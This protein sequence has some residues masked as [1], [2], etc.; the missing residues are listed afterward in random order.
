MVR[1]NQSIFSLK[2]WLFT[3]A[4]KAGSFA[5]AAEVHADALIID[6]ESR[7]ITFH[8]LY[9]STPPAPELVSTTFR[10]SST[11]QPNLITSFSPSATLRQSSI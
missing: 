10:R 9:E 5:R 2:S 8:V 6:L 4:T 1:S 3:P 11:P 7:R